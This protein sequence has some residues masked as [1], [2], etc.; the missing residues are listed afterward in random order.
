M[1]NL[2]VLIVLLAATVVPPAIGQEQKVP[3]VDASAQGIAIKGYDTVA[4]FEHS[5]CE[6][7]AEFCVHLE[8]GE[9]AFCHGG[10]SRHFRER[11]G[12][13]RAPIRGLLRVRSEPGSRRT[14]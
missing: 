14:D 13:V 11:A 3:P 4:Y 2:F 8:R 1:R 12:A 9:V 6:R 10:S 5:S 7:L